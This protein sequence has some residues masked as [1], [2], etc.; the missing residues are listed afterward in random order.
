MDQDGGR[1]ETPL[2]TPESLLGLRSPGEPH[3]G[4]SQ[5]GERCGNGAVVMDEPPIAIGKPQEPLEGLP[6]S[7]GWP[8]LHFAHLLW[9]HGDAASGDDVP[10]EGGRGT[11]ELTL[12][13]HDEQAV[14][15]E[16]LEHLADMN[17]VRLSIL[18][19][20]ENVVQIN[21]NKLVYHISQDIV[22]QGLEDGWRVREAERH[23]EVLPGPRRCVEGRL[24]FVTFL[25]PHKVLGIPEVQLGKDRR[26]LQEVK[27]SVHQRQRVAVAHRHAVDSP[28]I[29]A[30]HQGAV[31][32][33]YKE[34]PCTGW[35]R[36]RPDDTHC[37]QLCKVSLHGLPLW[38][39]QGE[40]TPPR[41]SCSRL[42]L[43][44]TVVRSVRWKAGST[45][46]AEDLA[47]V[48]VLPRNLRQVWSLLPLRSNH[49]GVGLLQTPARARRIQLQ[50]LV[51]RSI[52][53]RP[54]LR[55]PGVAQHNRRMRG[56]DDQEGDLL[57]MIP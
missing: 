18:G 43:D 40:D 34:E 54:V 33:P 26:S 55:H 6:V 48:V 46:L 15:Q 39:G 14:L 11:G 1:R 20:N 7:G 57:L 25:N 36:C 22:H 47:Q 5:V 9:V 16:A 4:G 35:G 44:R 51:L 45:T 28:V 50:D 19:E 17:L 24:P 31:L 27:R 30:G 23:D 52:H 56:V 38:A 10:Q 49:W 12:L 32:L 53:L 29:D 2:E 3:L 41:G 8:L 37:Q 42:E 13:C 21:K